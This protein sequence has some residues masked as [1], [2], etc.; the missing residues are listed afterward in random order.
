[1]TFEVIFIKIKYLRIYNISIH[2]NFYQN[3]SIN[4]KCVRKNFLKFSERQ[5][6]RHKDRVFLCDVEELMFLIKMKYKSL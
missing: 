1:M 4:Y 5:A 2:I 6:E 3:Q